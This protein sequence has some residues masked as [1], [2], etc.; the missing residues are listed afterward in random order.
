MVTLTCGTYGN[1]FRFLP[2]LSISDA[3]L[4][5]GIEGVVKHEP[6]PFGVA[7]RQGQSHADGAGAGGHAVDPAQVRGSPEGIAARNQGV[8]VGHACG[9]ACEQ[10]R[11]EPEQSTTRSTVSSRSSTN[12]FTKSRFIRALT[13]QSIARMSSPGWY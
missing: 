1:V 13:F 3:L 8:G 5:E 4:D 10:P 9:D 7:R 11:L 12:R 6:P 2:P